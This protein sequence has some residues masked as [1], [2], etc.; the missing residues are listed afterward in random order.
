MRAS[1]LSMAWITLYVIVP[2]SVASLVIGVV[3]SLATPWG[4]LR[5]YWVLVKFVLTVVA[6]IVLLQYTQTMSY[7]AGVA[8]ETS[9]SGADLR[10]LG[11]SPMLHASGGLLVLLVTTVL[12]VYKPRGLTPYG[13]RKQDE[14]RK[15]LARR[16]MPQP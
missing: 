9:S 8:A 14:Q 10:E 11:M 7:I 16:A 15:Q 1:F 4:L 2:L 6:T 13:W 3:Q 5:H 12:S